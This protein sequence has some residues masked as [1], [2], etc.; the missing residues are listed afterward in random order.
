MTEQEA[1]A[2]AKTEFWKTMSQEDRAFFQLFE[3]RL[4]MPFGVYHEALEKTLKRPVF[5]HELAHP[6]N[7]QKEMLG[8]RPRPTMD[9]II[10]LVPSEKRIVINLPE[11]KP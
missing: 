7:L 9:E 11:S 8:E 6:E 4:C 5:T 3:E 2:L 10:N 1:I